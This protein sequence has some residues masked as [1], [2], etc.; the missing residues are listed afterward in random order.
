VRAAIRVEAPTRVSRV[1]ASE[2][3]AGRLAGCLRPAGASSSDRA[4]SG[5]MAVGT[6]PPT[7]LALT[8]RTPRTVTG[9]DGLPNRPQHYEQEPD[10][11]DRKQDHAPRLAARGGDVGPVSVSRMRAPRNIPRGRGSSSAGWPARGRPGSTACPSCFALSTGLLT[12][13]LCSPGSLLNP[14]CLSRLQHVGQ[15]RVRRS[16]RAC[17]AL[18]GSA[19]ASRK[20]AARA[21]SVASEEV[22]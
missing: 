7:P 5:G 9:L 15:R 11:R 10:E 18:I 14:G 16:D 22:R 21:R 12:S 8:P 2:L 6:V 19:S 1:V 20:P 3:P 4:A 17:R 13:N